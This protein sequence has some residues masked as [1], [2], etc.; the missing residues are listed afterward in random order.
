MEQRIVRSTF[1]KF[2]FPS[3]A[4]SIMLSVISMTDLMIAGHFVGE[5]ALTTISLALPVIIFVQ[6]I[7]AF[8]GM[9]GA[10]ALSIRMGEGNLEE[11]NRIFSI[12][13][14]S[15][16]FISILT[17]ILGQQFLEPLILLL[18]GSPGIVMEQAKLYIGTLFWGMPF[19][20]LSPV[21]VVYLRND[22]EQ[23]YAMLCV[24]VAG[25][26]NILFS[27]LFVMMFHWGIFGIAMGTVVAEFLSCVLAGIRLFNKK[28][29]FRLVRTKWDGKT[30]FSILKPGLTLA[31]IFLSQILLT[32]VVNHVLNEYGGSEGMAVYAV[33]KYL[34]NF[35]FA[36][37]DGVTGAIQPMLG[38]YYGEKE[39][40]NLRYTVRYAFCAMMI[41]ATIMLIVMGCFGKQLC[42]LFNVESER[43][44]LMTVYAMQIL[45]GYCVVTAVMTFMNAFYRCTGKENLSFVIS[46]LDNLVFPISF[47]LLM[48]KGM[49][50]GFQGVWIGLLLASLSTFFV[51][52]IY[53]LSKKNGFLFI[54]SEDFCRPS[55]E[56][57]AIYPV[58]EKN[59]EK[60]LTD[61]TSY[62][63]ERELS[64][65]REF[66]INLAIEELVLNVVSMAQESMKSSYYVDIRITPKED[67]NTQLRIR[68]NLVQFNPADVSENE[69]FEMAAEVSRSE[70]ELSES[71][72]INELGI[73]IVKKIAKEYSYRRTIG[74]NSFMVTI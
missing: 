37:F 42:L 18:G 24:L 52:L 12:S 47:V 3:V 25:V 23:K 30:Y 62:C 54:K 64:V 38:I 19:L 17:L 7:S 69:V 46:I 11:C 70:A 61:V 67:G 66:L 65:K 8:F 34:I 28:R 5:S 55:D 9:G 45:A 15:T 39:A 14:I 26:G 59:I 16:F 4:S 1:F 31:A 73:G 44:V 20:M 32:I 27:F 50:M 72:G 40:D 21:M 56:F 63:A 10:I 60:M 36:L 29:M 68:D 51:W 71:Q 6:I 49:N 2:F 33:I 74:Y 48:S 43:L 41:V 22:N 13:M 57:H 35:M 53:C 58:Q